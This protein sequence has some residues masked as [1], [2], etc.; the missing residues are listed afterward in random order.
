MAL[1]LSKKTSAQNLL[2]RDEEDAL[3][4]RNSKKSKNGL[5]VIEDEEWPKLENVK[6]NSWQQGQSFAEKL[7]G[8]NG[9]GEER[10]NAVQGESIPEDM[11]T[12][13]DQAD[14]D[15]D[16][17]KLTNKEDFVHALTGGPWMIFDHYLTVRPWE[18]QFNP[19]RAKIDRVAVW[20]AVSGMEERKE[21]KVEANSA[22]A[23]EVPPPSNQDVWKV[24]HKPRRPRKGGKEKLQEG[25]RQQDGGS[26]FGILAEDGGEFRDGKVNPVLPVV[27]FSAE[28]K[29]DTLS[30]TI[31][32]SVKGKKS[33]A[34]KKAN[35]SQSVGQSGDMA[36][37]RQDQRKE[38]RS[39]EGIQKV[40][41]SGD[42][43]R[44]TWVI[45]KAEENKGAQLIEEKNEGDVSAVMQDVVNRE[46]VG[47]SF[48]RDADQNLLAP[49]DPGDSERLR[50]LTGKFWSGPKVLGQ[51]LDMED[52]IEEEVPSLDSTIKAGFRGGN[53]SILILVETKCEQDSK[54]RCLS[55]LGF[56]DYAFV[57][58]IGRSG[59]LILAW[60]SFRVGVEVIHTDRQFI[61]IRCSMAGVLTFFLTAVYSVPSPSLK[62]VLWQE[63]YRIS[64]LSDAPWAVIGDFNDILQ[65]CERSGGSTVNYSRISC[66]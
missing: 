30:M 57:P 14:T 15:S 54:F 45:S 20:G 44:S 22:N 39:R 61:H 23:I 18:P 12:D 47:L 21:G 17:V 16:D 2:S 58:S 11:L 5:N 19:A 49:P 35:K 65:S 56:D 48:D 13:K 10:S 28:P 52:D 8:I 3:Y 26:R 38:K 59:G 50:G 27:H 4:C 29:T 53:P 6:I 33:S 32:G 60:K 1:V 7:K 64:T 31:G 42:S 62:A 36:Q 43:S 51:D 24:V 41:K 37:G 34:K 46:A 63:L 25:V 55:R 40:E 66:F 9:K